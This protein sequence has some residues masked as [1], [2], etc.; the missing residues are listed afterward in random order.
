MRK[1]QPAEG[2]KGLALKMLND[3]NSRDHQDNSQKALHVQAVFGDSEPSK[4][5]DDEGDDHLTA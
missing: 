5:I 1:F 4:M 2:A 3:H